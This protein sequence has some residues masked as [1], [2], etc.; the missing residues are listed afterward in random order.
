VSEAEAF[1]LKPDVFLV[2]PWHFRDNLIRRAA[3]LLDRGIKLLFPLPRIELF[4][5]S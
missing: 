2:L 1:A 5:S 4:P 3:P